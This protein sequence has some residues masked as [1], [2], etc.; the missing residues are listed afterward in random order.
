MGHFDLICLS[1][2]LVR[3]VGVL[4]AGIYSFPMNSGKE[5]GNGGTEMHTSL[6]AGGLRL[7]EAGVR[8]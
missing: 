5:T 3:K 2:S 1:Q 6:R 8:Y 7:T 4:P